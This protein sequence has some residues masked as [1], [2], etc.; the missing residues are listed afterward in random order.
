MTQEQIAERTGIKQPTLSKVLRGAVK[1]VL[2]RRYRKLL[3]LHQ[4]MT[5]KPAAQSAGLEPHLY[6]R[7][8]S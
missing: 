7:A 4:E 6:G 5:G 8:R 1:D 2:S 3:L